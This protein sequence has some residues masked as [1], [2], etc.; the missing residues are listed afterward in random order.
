MS[1]LP[2]ESHFPLPLLAF[3]ARNSLPTES[4]SNRKQEGHIPVYPIRSTMASIPLQLAFP[5]WAAAI[6]L[7]LALTADSKWTHWLHPDD[8][9]TD[10]NEWIVE[11]LSVRYTQPESRARRILESALQFA[12][13]NLH[14]TNNDNFIT[15]LH[16]TA[17]RPQYEQETAPP[18]LE[19]GPKPPFDGTFQMDCKKERLVLR[20]PTDTVEWRV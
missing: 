15:A 13:C 18:A 2:A 3:A 7:V 17:S 12:T 5:C 6:W 8:N 20:K 1:K 14:S 4:A 16:F 11:K 10:I 9:A 19:P